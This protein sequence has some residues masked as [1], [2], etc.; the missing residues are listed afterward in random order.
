MWD[1]DIDESLG[2]HRMSYIDYLVEQ[3]LREEQMEIEKENLLY[4]KDSPEWAR[5]LAKDINQYMQD[6][7]ISSY[8]YSKSCVDLQKELNSIN[9]M[10]NEG[11]LSL[12]LSYFSLN[13]DS[14]DVIPGIFLIGRTKEQVYAIT[15]DDNSMYHLFRSVKAKTKTNFKEL[16]KSISKLQSFSML[17]K[18]SGF[19]ASYDDGTNAYDL[20]SII[21][22]IQDQGVDTFIMEETLIT[23]CYIDI[24][25]T[26]ASYVLE[27]SG[28]T[29]ESF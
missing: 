12:E 18:Y 21:Q 5:D 4:P 6:C 9:H 7:G 23:D 10:L 15:R 13:I 17:A 25:E 1:D 19:T 29:K 26:I 8:G 24:E 11:M 2:M 16:A 22:I 3:K 14:K 27:S 20:G 28:W